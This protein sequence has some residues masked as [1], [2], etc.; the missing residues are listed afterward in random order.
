MRS[1]FIC[2]GLLLALVPACSKKTTGGGKTAGTV[3]SAATLIHEVNGKSIQSKWIEARA[4][5][6]LDGGG[7]MSSGTASIRSC[8]DSILWISITKLGFEVL[9]GIVLRDSAFWVNELENTY[10]KGS[11]TDIKNK[12]KVPASLGDIQDLIFPVINPGVEYNLEKKD[13]VILLTQPG[14]LNK[15]FHIADNTRL[16]QT[17]QLTHLDTDLKLDYSD[18]KLT[19]GYWF[20]F[21]QN[22]Y[23][24]QPAEIH[25][26]KLKFT[27]VQGADHL[28]T[29]FRIPS[30]Y[31]PAE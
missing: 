20:P 8:K 21:L 29:P 10:W 1:A 12:Y 11:I 13:Q 15:R 30:D 22:L 23:I 4:Q 3:N 9:R 2:L 6:S 31:T 25:E 17:I 19:E 28:T 7:F 5:V 18:Y 24:R 27:Q 14:L 26:T 16:I